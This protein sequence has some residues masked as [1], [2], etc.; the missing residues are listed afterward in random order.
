[1]AIPQP[2]PQ[3]VAIAGGGPVWLLLAPFLDFH[4]VRSVVFNSEPK[5]R[6]HPKG[7]AHNSR[8]MEHHR[9]LGIAPSSRSVGHV[10]FLS[11]VGRPQWL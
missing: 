4:G 6:R 2:A 3:S 8:T 5:P 10:R 11:L 9:R 7:S 1:M